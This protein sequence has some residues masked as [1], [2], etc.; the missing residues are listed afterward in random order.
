[1]QPDS[2]LCLLLSVFNILTA[3]SGTL[4]AGIG[5][6]IGAYL[7]F[8]VRKRIEEKRNEPIL[9]REYFPGEVD[10][11]GEKQLKNKLGHL[12]CHEAEL[13]HMG[14]DRSVLA[15]ETCDF[16]S[17]D[18]DD[19]Y[20]LFGPESTDLNRPDRF[21]I[22]FEISTNGFNSNEYQTLE[23][24]M[25]C[26]DITNGTEICEKVILTYRDLQGY[27]NGTSININVT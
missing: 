2:V 6:F 8:V 11:S 25:L 19:N 5:S 4:V 18:S 23:T 14:F 21:L 22:V 9:V 27:D 13:K 10:K 24:E 20:I 26:L 16:P 15:F 17:Y 12:I 7:F 3:V 1:M